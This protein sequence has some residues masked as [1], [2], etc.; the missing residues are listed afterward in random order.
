MVKRLHRQLKAALMSH[1]DREH[2][3]DNVPIILL[4]IRSTFKPDINACATELVD[5]STLRLPGEF[6]EYTTP[7]TPVDVDDLLHRLRKVVRSQRPRPPRV[8][9]PSAYIDP[10]LKTR[11]SAM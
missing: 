2:W 5:G 4:G 9:N 11:L 10:R 8:S 1:A 7:P 3:V 6:L